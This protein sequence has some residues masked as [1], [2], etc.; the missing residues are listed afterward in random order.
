MCVQSS[1]VYKIFNNSVD[2]AGV[3]LLKVG[4]RMVYSTCSMNPVENEALVAEV[5]CQLFSTPMNPVKDETLVYST[6]SMISVD[7]DYPTYRVTY[8]LF[9]QPTG[10]YSEFLVLTTSSQSKRAL[11]KGEEVG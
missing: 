6:C 9:Y 3:S 5:M 10:N 11:G 1:E 8:A 2:Y 4:G 7:K